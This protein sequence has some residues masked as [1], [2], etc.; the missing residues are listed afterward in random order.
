M[1]TTK[2][3]TVRKPHPD[4]YPTSTKRKT[5][6]KNRR[7][8]DNDRVNYRNIFNSL[9]STLAKHGTLSITLQQC[10]PI[11]LIINRPHSALLNNL[12][13]TITEMHL[14]EGRRALV[15]KCFPRIHRKVT[16]SNHSGLA[17]HEFSFGLLVRILPSAFSLPAF[18]Y[19]A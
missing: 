19:S 3:V 4:T 6:R 8:Y 11:I 14:S 5:K 18:M 10:T 16:C 9:N 15:V 13:L 1:T 17:I 2:L 7:H 12:M